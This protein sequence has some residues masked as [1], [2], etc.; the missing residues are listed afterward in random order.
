MT[1]FKR[2]ANSEANK[3]GGAKE[4]RRSGAQTRS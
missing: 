2:A 1:S 4:N 3:Y